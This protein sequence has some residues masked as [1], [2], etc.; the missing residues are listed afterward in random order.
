M[1]Y[2]WILFS[3]L[4]F[5]L[6]AMAQ[7]PAA[8]SPKKCD[9]DFFDVKYYDNDYSDQD[10]FT[11]VEYY[12]YN[13]TDKDW[14]FTWC[15]YKLADCYKTEKDSFRGPT[16]KE[17]KNGNWIKRDKNWKT[18]YLGI[19]ARCSADHAHCESIN[20]SD[21]QWN[22]SYSN[23][24]C[25]A[26]SVDAHGFEYRGNK[27]TSPPT[28][29]C[30]SIQKNSKKGIKRRYAVRTRILHSAPG[31]DSPSYQGDLVLREICR[32]TYN[33]KTKSYQVLKDKMIIGKDGCI[34]GVDVMNCE[35]VIAKDFYEN[36]F[37]VT[38]HDPNYPKGKIVNCGYFK[39]DDQFILSFH[40]YYFN[41][42]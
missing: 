34:E 26:F 22:G 8:P 31:N 3:L 37:L 41:Q 17:D 15:P 14:A 10:E 4:L 33:K 38:N 12:D 1:K 21:K 27:K 5:P 32:T 13:Y 42:P 36:D 30:S 40:R 9:D 24:E 16:P 29:L 20:N 18:S 7:D 28:D 39:K 35:C 11:I 2:L 25:S 23:T 19:N 6:S